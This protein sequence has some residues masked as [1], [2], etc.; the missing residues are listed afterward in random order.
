MA[1]KL[2]RAVT[3]ASII[4]PEGGTEGPAVS[5]ESIS[6]FMPWHLFKGGVRTAIID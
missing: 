5:Y 6:K 3:S 1:S 4:I 2:T